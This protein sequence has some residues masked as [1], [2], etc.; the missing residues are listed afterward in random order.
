MCRGLTI[1][2]EE[3]QAESQSGWEG[4]GRVGTALSRLCRGPGGVCYVNSSSH[5]Q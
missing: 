4:S 3:R 1:G 5:S 2:L